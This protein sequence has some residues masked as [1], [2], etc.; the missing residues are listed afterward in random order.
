VGGGGGGGE[1][2]SGAGRM[3]SVTPPQCP[4]LRS[5]SAEH[6]WLMP[7]ILAIWEVDIRRIK[8]QGQP[9]QIVQ[10][11]P[12]SPKLPEQNEL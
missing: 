9:R 12:P 4:A 1:V 7:I 11:T 6:L 10:E 2:A 5:L 8:I 3:V